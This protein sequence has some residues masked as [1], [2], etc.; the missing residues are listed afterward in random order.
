M[1]TA[2][3]HLDGSTT[4]RRCK[5]QLPKRACLRRDGATLLRWLSGAASLNGLGGKQFQRTSGFSFMQARM[6]VT[7]ASVASLLAR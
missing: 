6:A 4:G 2:L 1:E 5:G 7:S 3:L